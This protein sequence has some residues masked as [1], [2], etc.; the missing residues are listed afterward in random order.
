VGVPFPIRRAVAENRDRKNNGFGNRASSRSSGDFGY[1][2]NQSK[3]SLN[4]SNIS[5]ARGGGM[6][7]AVNSANVYCML[8]EGGLV[9]DNLERRTEESVEQPMEDKFVR[10]GYRTHC[11]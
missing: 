10:A 4:V 11:G 3:R 5:R 6:K 2:R 8:N 9:I 7:G 1:G